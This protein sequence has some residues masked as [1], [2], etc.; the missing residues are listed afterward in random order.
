[1]LNDVELPIDVRCDNVGAV[2]MAEILSSEIRMHH[3]DTR[4]H[5]VC[6]HVKD[7]WI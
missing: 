5:F 1:M 2:I 7:G 4:Y 3:I 6:D